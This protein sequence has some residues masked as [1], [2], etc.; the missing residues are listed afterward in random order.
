M[1]NNQFSSEGFDLDAVT[2]TNDS[3]NNGDNVIYEIGG[4]AT[5][6]PVGTPPETVAATSTAKEN[7]DSTPTATTSKVESTTSVMDTA[8]S[9][10]QQGNE[11][12]KLGHYLEAYDLYTE[13]IEACPGDLKGPEI[14]KQRDEFNESERAKAFSRQRLEQEDEL[15]RRKLQQQ[16]QQ[17]NA[18]NGDGATSSTTSSNSKDSKSKE[19]EEKSSPPPPPAVFQLPPQPYGDKLAIYYCNRAASLVQMERYDDAIQD[20]DVAVLL[21]PVYAKGYVRRSTAYERLEKTEEALRD[22][23][24]ALE[25]EPTNATLKKTVARLQK[26]E[27]ERLEKLKTETLGKL[28]ELG[29][30]ILGNFGLSLDNFQAVQDPATG[31]YSISFNQGGK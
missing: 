8:E 16:Q 18:N 26:L 20:C 24:K 27:E 28:K 25:L 21:N 9:W 14:L 5:V 23:Q 6:E 2:D 1:S 22:A 7:D 12:F 19:D 17:K 30:S 3:S 4:G 10:K 11:Q 15:R 13:A 31:S 29:N